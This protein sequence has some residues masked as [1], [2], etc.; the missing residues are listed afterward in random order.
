MRRAILLSTIVLGGA[1]SIGVAA[2]DFAN[3]QIRAEQIK[4]GLAVLF[5]SGGNIGL[6]HGPDGTIIVDDQFAPLTEKIQ[7]AIAAQ[8]ATP[9]KF[10]I[11]THLHGDHSGGNE[12]FGKAGATIFAQSN[13]RTRLADG[14][15]QRGQ[16][17]PPAPHAALPVVTYDQGMSFHANGD[18]VDLRY[19]GGGHT[20]GDSVIHWRKANAIHVGDMFNNSGG[21]PFIDTENG[22][23][24]L[25]LVT[26]LDQ[27]IAL[28]DADTV[29]I[30]GHGN[31]AR[32][33]E[34]IAWRDMIAG[35]VERVEALKKQGM[36]LEAAQAAK[37]LTG[38]R[39]ANDGGD[40]FVLGIWQSLEAH[41]R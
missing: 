20:D 29:I 9:V 7:A 35:A 13:V 30:P 23:N 26:S 27:V 40:A 24:A 17:R 31:L 16:P 41:G 18:T 2:Q 38:L 39:T 25:H 28:A 14:G 6:F 33:G 1:I 11:N 15:T 12:N 5:G 19:F 3:V 10:L 4:P 37:P 34:L 22:G 21:F 32:R 36:T 8:G